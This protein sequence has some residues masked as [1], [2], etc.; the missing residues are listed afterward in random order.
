VDRP[1]RRNDRPSSRI[2]LATD[3]ELAGEHTRHD[4][5]AHKRHRD[6]E[7]RWIRQA[8]LNAGPPVSIVDLS[9]GGAL[10][11]SPVA[12]RPDS[13]LMLDIDGRGFDKTLQFRV[14]RCEV[15]TLRPGQTIYRGACEFTT[16]IELP[17]EHLGTARVLYP[18]Q[19]VGVNA[20]LEQL[21]E[22]AGARRGL[23]S[24]DA[25][26]VTR[27]TAPPSAAI[28][29]QTAS[30]L[31]EA[32]AAGGWQKI[33]VRYVEG[34]V[35]KGYSQ[36]FS[37][38]RA[39]FSLWPSLTSSPNERV[40]VPLA[41]LKGVFFVRDFAGNPGYVERSETEQSQHGR[42][43]EVTLVDHEVIAGRTLTYRPDGH[44]FFV[45]PADPLA[46]N[47][48]VFIV[49]SAVRQVRFP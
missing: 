22:R 31:V 27:T 48:R 41:R 18:N 16:S 4:R 11:D 8:R 6:E 25:G 9:S 21:V 24:V 10:I 36:D 7:L 3:R 44:G 46:N 2:E 35:L 14:I 40:I 37:A 19:F 29:V 38:A 1:D 28:D 49:A 47:I 15:G 42:R 39:Q 34:Q 20:T 30:D 17:A 32:P 33:V 45:M 12:L 23:G 13:L 26:A 5:R 43:I